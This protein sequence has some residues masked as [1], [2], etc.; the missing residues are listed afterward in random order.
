MTNRIILALDSNTIDIDFIEKIKDKLAMVK[1]GLELFISNQNIIKLL[2]IPI[3]LDLKLWDIPNTIEKSITAACLNY[4]PKYIT[5]HPMQEDGIKRGIEAANKF[6]CELIVVTCLTSLDSNDLST[7]GMRQFL[8]TD[9][10]NYII[11]KYYNLGIKNFVMSGTDLESIKNNH[12]IIKF[13]PGIR[14]IKGNDDQ[15]R[16]VNHTFARQAGA[17]YLIIGREITTA[18]NPILHLNKLNEDLL[19]LEES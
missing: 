6:N 5:I 7:I 19:A 10:T 2:N 18:P 17:D 9:R 14:S 4:N 8:P 1:V 3:F 15:K 13:V 16:I 12:N 11:E